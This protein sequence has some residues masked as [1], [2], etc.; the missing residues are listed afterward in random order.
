MEESQIFLSASGAI[1]SSIKLAGFEFSRNIRSS[2][3][4]RVINMQHV[5]YLDDKAYYMAKAII[6][7]FDDYVSKLRK[8]LIKSYKRIGKIKF[9]FKSEKEGTF[10]SVKSDSENFKINIT[11]I[12][13]K[14]IDDV[15]PELYYVAKKHMIMAQIYLNK[16]KEFEGREFDL[17]NLLESIKGDDEEEQFKFGMFVGMEPLL[18]NGAI[19]AYRKFNDN[20]FLLKYKKLVERFFIFVAEEYSKNYLEKILQNPTKMSEKEV[21]ERYNI[22]AKIT[23]ESRST[24]NM[25]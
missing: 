9:S 7:N 4:A 21:V 5:D 22:I 6:T 8:R 25:V 1:E 16:A 14:V 20:D 12:F 23:Q 15:N 24:F 3:D 18:V 11:Y 19:I 2:S 10:L 13:P 17:F